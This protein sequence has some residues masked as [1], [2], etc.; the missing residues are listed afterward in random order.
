MLKGKFQSTKKYDHNLGFSVAFR[1]HRAESHCHLMHGYSMAFKFIFE[2]DELDERG[3]VVDFGGLKSLKAMLE[4][5][6]DH[7]TVIAEDDPQLDYFLHGD[8]LGV[9]DLV[10][11]PAV[12]VEKFAEYVFECTEQWLK[13]AGFSPRCWLVSVEVSEHPANSAIYSRG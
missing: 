7:K 9:L 10:I 2:A 1:Q 5:T 11:L 4:T 8:F 13:D 12:G 6:F 3:W